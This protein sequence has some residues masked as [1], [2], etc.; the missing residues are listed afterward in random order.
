[1]LSL[2]SFKDFSSFC[3]IKLKLILV[4]DKFELGFAPFGSEVKD[5][6]EKRGFTIKELKEAS[7]ISE[8]KEAFRYQKRLTIPLH[9]KDGTLIGFTGREVQ[10]NKEF[11]VKYLNP[12]NN[13]FYQK[14]LKF[15]L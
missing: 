4:I 10:E 12:S 11:N 7:L 13:E 6:L 9:D 15:I 2:N 3:L 5:L 8:E 1:M 14:S